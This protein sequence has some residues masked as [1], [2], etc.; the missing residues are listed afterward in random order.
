MG[1]SLA[2]G[3]LAAENGEEKTTPWVA[4]APGQVEPGSGEVRV[5]TGILGRVAEVLVKVNDKV[6]EDELLIRLEDQEAR[7]RLSAAEAQAGAARSER[8]AQA[9]TS[10]REDVRKAEDA[11]YAA[12]RAFTGARYDLDYALAAKRQ[13]T[14][15]E[16]QVSDARR[17]LADAK[18][19]FLRERIAFATAQ[20]KSNLPAPNRFESAT[21]TARAEVAIA[22]ALL[23]KTRIRAPVAGSV[24]RIYPTVGDVVAP[25]PDQPLAVLGDMSSLRVKAEVDEGDVS[26]IK[27]GQKAFVRSNSYPG[28]EFEG[29][30]AKIAP[31]LAPPRIA[32]RGPRRP[33][34]VDVLEVTIDLDGAVSLLPGMRVDAFFRRD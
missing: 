29:K 11:V 19:R 20:A 6:E 17:R 34:D 30:V 32:G 10:G 14:G 18:D 7:A 26:K 21:S 23:D 3:T 9:A 12:E 2:A 15:T 24:L 27:L 5:G 4:A 8:D 13:G 16:Q 28:K 33:N 22:Q 1:F 25:S 31:S